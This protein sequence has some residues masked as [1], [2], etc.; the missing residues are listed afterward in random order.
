MAYYIDRGRERL[1][2]RVRFRDEERERNRERER[3]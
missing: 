1:Y 2:E 3:V